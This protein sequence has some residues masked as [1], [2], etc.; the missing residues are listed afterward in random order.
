VLSK[1]VAVLLAA[2]LMALMMI[3]VVGAVPVFAASSGSPTAN[4]KHYCVYY[5]GYH[6]VSPKQFHKHD[7]QRTR[8]ASAKAKRLGWASA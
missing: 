3:V 6:F 5:R 7:Y 1:K 4:K 8:T 2:A